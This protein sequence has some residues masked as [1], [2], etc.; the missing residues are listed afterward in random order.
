MLA[1]D[2]FVASGLVHLGYFPCAS[3]EPSVALTTRVLEVYRVAHL[4][5]PRLAIQPFVKSLCDIHGVPFRPYLSTQFSIA[6]D[7]YLATLAIVNK[8]VLALLRRDTPNWRLANACAPCMYKLEDEPPMLF[9]ILTTHDGNNSLS[10]FW[11]QERTE[12]GAPGGSKERVDDREVPGD[13][14]LSRE[15]VDAWGKAELEELMKGFTDEPDSD[16]G[17]C[18]D[19]WQNMKEEITSKAW[20]MYDETGVFLSLCRHGFV[21]VIADMVRSGELSK[22][23]Y[24]VVHHLIH[25]LGEVAAGYDIGCKFGKMVQAHPT[26]GPLARAHKFCSLVGA[27]HGHGHNRLCQ[28]CNLATYVTGMGLEDLEECETF[29]SKSNALAAG[30]R[31]ATRFHRQQAIATYLQHVDT[32]DTYQS[33][34][35]VLSNKYKRALEVKSTAPALTAAMHELGVLSKDTFVE[36]LA[37]EK[38]CLQSLQREPLE[39]TLQ[40]EYYQKL[41]N[42]QEQTKR[43]DAVLAVTVAPAVGSSDGSYENDARA[44]RRLEAQRRHAMELHN[45]CLLAVHDLEWRMGIER[46]EPNSPEWQQTAVMVHRRRYQRALDQLQALI[47]ARM[48]ELTKMNMSGTGYKL[49]KHIAKALQARSR[50]VKTALSNY[51]AAASTLDPPRDSLTWEQVV[52]YAFLSDFDLLRDGREDIRE[53]LWAKP[54]GR[55]AMDMH[56]KIERADEEIIRLN[57]EIRRLMTYMRDEEAFLG[58]E[59]RRIREEHGGAIAYQV[60]RYRFRQ[61]RF[62][63]THRLRLWKLSKIPGFTGRLDPGTAINKDRLEGASMTPPMSPPPLAPVDNPEES[64]SDSEGEAELLLEQFTLMRVTEDSEGPVEG[65]ADV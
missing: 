65:R 33:L 19:R 62:N 57:I 39:E 49:R 17:G 15:K 3:K 50:A 45:K 63:E 26:L 61:G 24:A 42:L 58:R 11:R 27:F 64:G 18:S 14:Y 16:D 7:L 2:A 10:R 36:W 20:G 12:D 52:E 8:R 31:Y 13:Y 59:E 37:R 30:T 35:L 55:I 22:Y 5:C 44:T 40:M 32:F 56:F 28:L 60:R 21:L 6:F 48:F 54:A 38:A 43:M 47:I 29:F 23:G 51:N 46:W 9:P 53:E 1:E 25:V 41:V 4:R 34:S